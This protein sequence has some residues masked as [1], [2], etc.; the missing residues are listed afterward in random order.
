[1]SVPAFLLQHGAL[2][3]SWTTTPI[4]PLKLGTQ[5]SWKAA[6]GGGS[7]EQ[8]TIHPYKKVLQ[9]TYLGGKPRAP[10]LL[11][12]W[13]GEP[14]GTRA[15]WSMH[16]VPLPLTQEQLAWQGFQERESGALREL[17]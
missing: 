7:G 5:H 8:G 14:M 9:A 3:I 16:K 17:R 10:T 11:N 2:C 1:M 15:F 12:Y 6:G 13:T 4:I